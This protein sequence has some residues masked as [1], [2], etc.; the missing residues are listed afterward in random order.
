MNS[1]IINSELYHHGVKGQ[2]WGVRRYQPYPK[3]KHGTFLGQ[4]RDDDIRIKKGTTAYRVQ[5]TDKLRGEGHTYISIDKLEHLDYIGFASERAGVMVDAKTGNNGYSIKMKLSNDIIAPSYQKSIDAFIDTVD[6]IGLKEVA[7]KVD[8]SWT[9]YSAKKFIKDV[10][11]LGIEECRDRAYLNFTRTMMDD[12]LTRKTF[13]ETLE[14]EGYNAIIDEWDNK[15][16]TTNQKTPL[17]IFD[18]NNDLTQVS[19]RK[20]EDRDVEYAIMRELVDESSTEKA[21][22]LQKRW[23]DY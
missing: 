13:F 18:K 5:S 2:K 16:G 6:K 3:G 4:D 9:G 17:I 8:N 23:K 14:K 21:L 11:K 12:E 1:K 19:S 20:I 15:F 22:E 10:K 7:D